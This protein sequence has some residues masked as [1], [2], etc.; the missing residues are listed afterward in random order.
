MDRPAERK[1]KD[2]QLESHRAPRGAESANPARLAGQSR[3]VSIFHD[4]C[5]A[6]QYTELPSVLSVICS[7]IAEYADV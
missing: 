7:A 5:V 2:R 6:P 4:P 1:T 3:S